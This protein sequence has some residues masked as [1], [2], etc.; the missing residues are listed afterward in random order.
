MIMFVGACA[1]STGG[2]IKVSRI[3]ILVKAGVQ[4]IRHYVHPRSVNAVRMDGKPVERETVRSVIMYVGIYVLIFCTSILFVTIFDGGESLETIFTAVAATFNNIGPGLDKVGPM[5]NYGG[6]S[7]LSKY[8]LMFDMLAG[9]LEL[10]PMMM[11]FIPA[12][13][14]KR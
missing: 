7:V 11:L 12:I 13:W 1:G 14:R 5:A 6:L 8:T 2:G 10:Y 9:R 3:V 4:E